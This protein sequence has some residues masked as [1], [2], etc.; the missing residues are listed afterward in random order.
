MNSCAPKTHSAHVSRQLSTHGDPNCPNPEAARPFEA[1][2]NLHESSPPPT[3][4]NGAVDLPTPWHSA[5]AFATLLR[6]LLSHEFC[7]VEPALMPPRKGGLAKCLRK[8]GATEMFLHVI[9]RP[10]DVIFRPGQRLGVFSVS[11]QASRHSSNLGDCALQ[12]R[13]PDGYMTGS[14]FLHAPTYQY[15]TVQ[16][17]HL[18]DCDGRRRDQQNGR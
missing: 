16:G 8:G 2:L 14:I 7:A 17:Q 13:M 9:V 5:V 1:P 11:Q 15:R 6:R 18:S 3:R 4:T 10:I 12:T